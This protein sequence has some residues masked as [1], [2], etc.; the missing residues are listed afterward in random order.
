[1]AA[2]CPNT[3]FVLGGISQGALVIDLITIAQMP[4]AG[5]M[6]A[7]LPAE[8]ADRVAAVARLRESGG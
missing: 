4:I 3:R 7:T 8:V 5:F 6:P 1:M 2:D